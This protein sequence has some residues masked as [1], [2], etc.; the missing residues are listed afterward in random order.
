VTSSKKKEQTMKKL[1]QLGLIITGAAVFTVTAAS[2]NCGSGKEAPKQMKCQAGKCGSGMEKPK[3]M[4]CQ[5][6]KSG[7]GKD[8]N[9]TKKAPAKGK[10]GQG[11]CG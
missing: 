10:C 6:G 11:K 9:I 8:K 5:A 1:L 4:K 7:A 2:A 3:G